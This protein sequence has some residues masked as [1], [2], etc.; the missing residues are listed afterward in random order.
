MTE[1][2]GASETEAL[3]AAA[4][5]AKLIALYNVEES[6]LRLRTDAIG[7]VDDSYSMPGRVSHFHTL[8][9]KPIAAFTHT[10]LRWR[11]TMEDIFG[12]GEEEPWVYVR[13]HGYPLDVEAAITLSAIAQTSIITE[14]E[15]WEKITPMPRKG[16]GKHEQ[17]R[18]EAERQSLKQSFFFGIC[19]RLG[20]RIANFTVQAEST[21]TALMLVKDD[22]VDQHYEAFLKA[23]NLGLR[24]SSVSSITLND[25]AYRSGR[26][27][28]EN[29]D[30]GR[31]ER[32]SA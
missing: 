14:S 24:V 28:A 32:L 22:L 31:N 12:L 17:A 25:A 2:S 20:E 27:S 4:Q 23:K 13:F 7:M 8:V 1:A 29:V 11:Q 3:M 19:E 5:V 16:K 9:A 26:S 21:G 10:K 30:L 15:R 6:E 18:N